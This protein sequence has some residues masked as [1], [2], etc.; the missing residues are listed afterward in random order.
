[1]PTRSPATYDGIRNAW[2]PERR[3]A[4][5]KTA[6]SRPWFA[7]HSDVLSPSGTSHETK[8]PTSV[9]E[10]TQVNEM[11]PQPIRGDRGATILGPHNVALEHENRDHL[12]SPDAESTRGHSRKSK[13]S[14]PRERLDAWNGKP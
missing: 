6:V 8:G 10:T 7:F 1:M 9:M 13:H 14:S 11:P 12:D 2:T 5:D 3:L 4:R